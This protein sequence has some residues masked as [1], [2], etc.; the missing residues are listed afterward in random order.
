M[1][2]KFYIMRGQL[3]VTSDS[4][5]FYELNA[6]SGYGSCLNNSATRCE[7][8][9]YFGPIPEGVYYVDPADLSDPNFIGDV[10]R[11][12]TGDWGDWRIRIKPSAMTNTYG[13]GNF[14]IHGGGTI[15]SAGCIDVGGGIL[16]NKHTDRLKQDI[17]ATKSIIRL[18][19]FR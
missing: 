17:R 9:Q 4:G 10:R 13:R 7:Q 14:F 3:S 18:E 8:A 16:G 2:M 12:L 19:V 6:S 15:G 1:E 11:R 5:I